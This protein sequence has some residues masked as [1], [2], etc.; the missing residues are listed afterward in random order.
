PERS[1]R[2][3]D[4]DLEGLRGELDPTLHPRFDLLLEGP[5]GAPPLDDDRAEKALI[6]GALRLRQ[7]KLQRLVEELRLLQADA[8]ELGGAA[9]EEYGQ[10]VDSYRSALWGISQALAARS[11]F[12]RREA[13]LNWRLEIGGWKV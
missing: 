9:I 12:G 4:I 2:A 8:E 3:Q 11:F 1:R 5:K 6:E 13:S 7:R 10:V